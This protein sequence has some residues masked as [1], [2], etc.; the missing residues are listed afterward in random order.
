MQLDVS[1]T[2]LAILPWYITETVMLQAVTGM[3][4]VGAE[5]L[6][7]K[8]RI[9]PSVSDPVVITDCRFRNKSAG[10]ENKIGDGAGAGKEGKNGAKA[11]AGRSAAFEKRRMQRQ[12]AN[13][14]GLNAN[15]GNADGQEGGKPGGE[16]KESPADMMQKLWTVENLLTVETEWFRSASS[17]LESKRL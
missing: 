11:A 6:T 4:H 10:A 15:G 13:G 12:V 5:N 9:S 16:E 3:F 7:Q 17:W 14:L 8:F 2:F 1:S